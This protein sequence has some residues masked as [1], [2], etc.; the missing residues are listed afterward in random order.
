MNQFFSCTRLL[1]VLSVVCLLQNPWQ[2]RKSI[3][4]E[5]PR[6]DRLLNLIYDYD[7]AAAERAVDSL[8]AVS[9]SDPKPY[10]FMTLVRWWYFVGD[11][12]S[13][14]L[15]SS[16][17]AAAEKAVE[18]AKQRVDVVEDAEEARFYLGGAYGY[19]AR[20]YV[21]TNS[22]L[23]AYYY[24]KKAKSI[25]TDLLEHNETLYDANLAVGT[26]NYYADELPAVVR[27]F[28]AV[29]GLGGDK[30]LGIEQL[31]LAADSGNYSRIEA[32]SMLGHLNL[33]FESNFEEA[34]EIFSKL[35]DKYGANPVFRMLLAKSYRKSGN[36]DKAISTCKD[37]LNYPSVKYVSPNQ[38][39]GVHAELAYCYMLAKD[40]PHAI[41]EY[42]Q[43][44][45]LAGN[46]FLKES[47]WIYYN[48]GLCE[49]SERRYTAAVAYYRKVLGCGDF[50]DYH[51]LAKKSI[52]RIQNE[53]RG[54]F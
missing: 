36:Y 38:L 12:N 49:E 34:V 40:Y 18:I 17:L 32:L 11:I 23:D 50:F 5:E 2:D 10:F 28:A 4:S 14:Q 29:I 47:P 43:C 44:E 46:E 31:H 1:C 39:A 27:I 6:Y 16:F 52:E 30:R 53:H 42:A 19:L 54:G 3:S 37:L 8:I 9:P 35:S 22:W 33:E 15:K 51:S 48:A 25:F 21:F 41:T 13:Q 20:Y 45:R 26:Y 7:L 24:G